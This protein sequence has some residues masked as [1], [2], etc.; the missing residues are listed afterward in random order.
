MRHYSLSIKTYTFC[1]TSGNK[2]SIIWLLST[3]EISKTSINL[4]FISDIFLLN[5]LDLQNN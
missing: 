1:Q 4:V 5:K 2:V 3:Y